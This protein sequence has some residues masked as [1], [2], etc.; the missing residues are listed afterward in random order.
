MLRTAIQRSLAVAISIGVLLLAGSA[1]SISQLEPPA[2]GALG[3]FPGRNGKIAFTRGMPGKPSRIYLVNPDGRGLREQRTSFRGFHWGADW[4]P[5]GKRLVF[6]HQPRGTDGANMSIVNADGTGQ[7]AVTSD[8]KKS[9]LRDAPYVKDITSPKW[10]P[11]GRR[12]AFYG[13]RLLRSG[14]EQ[15]G[16]YVL[17]LFSHRLHYIRRGPSGVHS[18]ATGLAWSPDGRRLAVPGDCAGPDFGPDSCLA[19]GADIAVIRLDGKLVRRIQARYEVQGG[20]GID[21]SPDGRRLL[22]VGRPEKGPDGIFTVGIGGGDRRLV[23]QAPLR[24]SGQHPS[25]PVFSPDGTLI[26]FSVYFEN[27]NIVG[28]P[29][30]AIMNADGTGLRFITQTP[31]SPWYS[32][33]P[34]W[35]RRPGRR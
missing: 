7:K 6:H 12:I 23:Y 3:T 32:R 21:W 15:P 1:S 30:I 17:N 28:A 18:V 13:L 9:R 2:F 8:R 20:G 16:V 26:A 5:D 31:P 14:R 33:Y 35:Q 29:Q 24:G 11:D 27:A 22:Y 34:T 10:S 25:A 19:T 4:S